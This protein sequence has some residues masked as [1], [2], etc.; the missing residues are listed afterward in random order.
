MRKLISSFLV[1]IITLVLGFSQGEQN[2]YDQLLQEAGGFYASG[3]YGDSVDKFNELVCKY[4]DDA[5]ARIGRAKVLTK[6]KEFDRAIEDCNEA[7]RVEPDSILLAVMTRGDVYVEQGSYSEAVNDFSE[8]LRFKKDETHA[9]NQR[10]YAYLMLGKYNEA[11]LDFNQ[12]ISLQSVNRN[13]NPILYK[14]RGYTYAMLGK[15]K[16][17]LADLEKALE[18]ST[19]DSE[20]AEIQALIQK[21]KGDC[22]IKSRSIDYEK[23]L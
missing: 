13:Q 23:I 4:P 11:L 2:D 19:T 15:R 6:M 21:I 12:A 1:L 14:N 5:L 9:Y 3:K 18:F 22:K 17:A 16:E 8:V 10:G 20:R 7:I